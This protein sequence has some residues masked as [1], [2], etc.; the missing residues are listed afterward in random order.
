[1]FQHS[2]RNYLIQTKS[3]PW[4]PT[5][6]W[7]TKDNSCLLYLNRFMVKNVT[8]LYL[9]Y[10]IRDQYFDIHWCVT[11]RYYIIDHSSHFFLV[12]GIYVIEC[13]VN[14][15]GNKGEG[16]GVECVFCGKMSFGFWFYSCQKHHN[17]NNQVG[18]LLDLQ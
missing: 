16:T 18:V 15:K 5:E 7:N 6:F 2:I 9:T 12:N 11:K 10:V 13:L 4:N 1:M 8:I 17:K 3:I 14:W